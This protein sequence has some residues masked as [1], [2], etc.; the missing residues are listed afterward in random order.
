MFRPNEPNQPGT[1]ARR[2]NIDVHNIDHKTNLELHDK[3]TAAC[4]SLIIG[5]TSTV[6]PSD[7]WRRKSADFLE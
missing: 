3:N 4:S 5:C 1:N 2:G 6:K 7:S